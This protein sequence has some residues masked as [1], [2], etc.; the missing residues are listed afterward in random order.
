MVERADVDCCSSSR[1]RPDKTDDPATDVGCSG[2][3]VG[4]ESTRS[5]AGPCEAQGRSSD[6]ELAVALALELGTARIRRDRAG[7]GREEGLNEGEA[8]GA[9]VV[10]S[11]D[12]WT[13]VS[14]EDEACEHWPSTQH[15]GIAE[16]MRMGAIMR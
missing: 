11:N 13:E 7:R 2:K 4:R 10:L 9:V 12:E 15:E 1:V 16:T 5:R 6:A 8:S 14:W 3:K